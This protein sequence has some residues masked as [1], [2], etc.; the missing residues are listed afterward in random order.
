VNVHFPDGKTN[1]QIK[2]IKDILSSLLYDYFFSVDMILLNVRI[3]AAHTGAAHFVMAVESTSEQLE[4]CRVV[5]IAK[6]VQQQRPANAPLSP[7]R[8][9]PKWSTQAVRV[10]LNKS[11]APRRL[12]R[13]HC[14][15]SNHKRRVECG[16]YRLIRLAH[17]S[18]V[19][20]VVIPL[21][22]SDASS[23]AA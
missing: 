7:L 21:G 12:S 22:L 14:T 1:L 23:S 5:E 8:R 6:G 18:N 19:M 11:S 13:L 20:A 15:A 16:P 2:K 3:P 4:G 17:S 9:T 10:A